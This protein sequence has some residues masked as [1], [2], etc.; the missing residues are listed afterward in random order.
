MLIRKEEPDDISICSRVQL[1]K[2]RMEEENKLTE[3]FLRN[4]GKIEV[5]E[6]GVC[7][8]KYSFNYRPTVNKDLEDED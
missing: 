8:T 2:K 6:K 1:N 4:G 5:I 7:A 3:E